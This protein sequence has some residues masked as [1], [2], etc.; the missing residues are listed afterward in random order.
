M[1]GSAPSSSA[2]NLDQSSALLKQPVDLS[3]NGLR[4]M[5]FDGIQFS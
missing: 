1:F 3:Q 5:I 4:T 2:A